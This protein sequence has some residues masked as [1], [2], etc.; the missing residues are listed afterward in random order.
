MILLMNVWRKASFDLP[1]EIDE[2]CKERMRRKSDPE[3]RLDS[4]ALKAHYQMATMP[5]G[6]NVRNYYVCDDLWVPICSISHK[7]YILPGI[8]QLF[9]RMLKA[10][11]YSNFEKNI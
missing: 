2:E 5:K 4:D 11:F 10:S 1:C 7:V 6:K 8:P 3:A 9:A